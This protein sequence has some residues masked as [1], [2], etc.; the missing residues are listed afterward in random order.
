M[1]H[2]GSFTLPGRFLQPFEAFAATKN[3]RHPVFKK[4]QNSNVYTKVATK[5][6]P[7]AF[8]VPESVSKK[9]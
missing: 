5:A 9:P 8:R 4:P 6:N 1:H 7:P 2:F 3:E